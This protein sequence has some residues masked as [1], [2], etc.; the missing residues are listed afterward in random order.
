MRLTE[1]DWYDS[2][3]PRQHSLLKCPACGGPSSVINTRVQKDGVYR[4][5]ACNS[6]R[7]RFS[8]SEAEVSYRADEVPTIS[9]LDRLIA[10]QAKDDRSRGYRT[11]GTGISIQTTRSLDRPFSETDDR[12]LYNVVAYKEYGD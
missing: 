5:R 10:E 9:E 7:T 11:G 12:T 6:C 1:E 4:R 2:F 8:T 3:V